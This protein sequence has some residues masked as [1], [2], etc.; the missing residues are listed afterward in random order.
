MPPKRQ[1]RRPCGCGRSELQQLRRQV[2][3]LKL[4]LRDANTGRF[5]KRVAAVRLPPLEQYAKIYRTVR[6]ENDFANG[7]VH[8]S[9]HD[10]S[11]F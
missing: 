7:E 11:M 10:A 1:R 8:E 9:L 3:T 5:S 2:Q 4:N 6:H